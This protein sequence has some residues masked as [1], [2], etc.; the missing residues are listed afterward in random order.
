MNWS[1]WIVTYFG[2][3]VICESKTILGDFVKTVL[4]FAKTLKQRYMYAF[5]PNCRNSRKMRCGTCMH[6]AQTVE[7]LYKKMRCGRR[8]RG[9][10]WSTLCPTSKLRCYVI[11][12]LRQIKRMCSMWNCSKRAFCGYSQWSTLSAVSD[13]TSPLKIRV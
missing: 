4:H 12:Y 11:M 8:G 7:T 6:F 13:I 9:S 1:T 5:C 2:L 3:T 10:W